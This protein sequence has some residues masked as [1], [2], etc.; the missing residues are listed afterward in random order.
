VIGHPAEERAVQMG[1]CLRQRLSDVRRRR[2]TPATVV[3]RVSN[4]AA[5]P[6][7]IALNRP[8][9]TNTRGTSG[10]VAAPRL[11]RRDKRIVQRF[12]GAVEIADETDQRRQYAPGVRSINGIDRLPECLGIRARHGPP[13]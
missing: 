9:D 5:Q 4:R 10:T 2:V 7:S 11:E 6:L 13:S 1:S 8:V 3:A 12:F